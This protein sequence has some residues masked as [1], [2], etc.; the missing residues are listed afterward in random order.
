LRGKTHIE[1]TES[2]W[3][4]VTGCSKVSAGCK[5]C[6]AMKLAGTRLKHHP[7]R[8]GLTKPSPAGNVWTGEV[9]FNA[10]WL[11]Q[12]L[13]W[14]RP[15]Q[16]FVCA[17]S[18]LFHPDVPTAWQDKVFVVM[19]LAKRHTFQVL[20]KRPHLMLNYVRGLRTLAGLQRL[21]A[22]AFSLA[23]SKPESSRQP[24]SCVYSAATP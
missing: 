20:T 15:R 17:H 10:E 11:T 16:I 6:Y 14:A 4:P 12:P 21:E 7:S 3:N 2:T 23:S 9:R 13:R 5:N 8:A 18:D 19:A 22:A 24:P 1:W